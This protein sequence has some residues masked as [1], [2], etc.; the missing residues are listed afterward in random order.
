MQGR[1]CGARRSTAQQW[2][3]EAAF[4]SSLQYVR[5][6]IADL[7]GESTCL[8]NNGFLP[9]GYHDRLGLTCFHLV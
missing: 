2:I 7:Y 1:N 4:E 6:R 9:G 5:D 8:G 3:T